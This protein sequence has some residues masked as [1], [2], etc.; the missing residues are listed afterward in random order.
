[1]KE[2]LIVGFDLDNVLVNLTKEERKIANKHNIKQYA[3]DWNF[4]NYPDECKQEIYEMFKN[5]EIMCNLKPFNCSKKLIKWLQNRGDKVYI[6]TAR[7]ENVYNETIEYVNKLFNINPIVVGFGE[8]KIDILKELNVDTWIDDSPKEM[9][10]IQELG[11][12]CILISNKTTVYNHHARNFCFWLPSVRKLYE[13]L[14][15]DEIF[16]GG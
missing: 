13:Y 5:P 7:Y 1:M 16:K 4:S 10:Q 15:N 8:S 14:T 3:K 12:K 2:K 9:K 6:I 11:I